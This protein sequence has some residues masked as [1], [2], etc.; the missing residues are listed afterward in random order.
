MKYAKKPSAI[1]ILLYALSVLCVS[2][3]AQSNPIIQENSLPGTTQWQLSNPAN[4]TDL[5]IKGYASATSVNQG[6]S[7]DFHVAVNPVQNFRIDIYRLGWYD[8]DG[9]RLVKSISSVT[10]ETQPDL[11]IDADTGLISAPWNI[12]HTLT[13]PTS[14][15]SGIY[16]AKITN[17]AGFDNHI[18]FV[19][20]DDNRQADL[21]YQ[22]PVTTYQ[23]YNSFPNDQ[24]TGKSLYEFS[25]FGLPTLTGNKRAVRVSFNRPYS[26]GGSGL[27]FGWE[28]EFIRWVERE[29]YDIAYSTNIDTHRAGSKLI[30]YRAFLSVGH[31]EYWSKEMYDAAEKARNEGVH[32]GF[33]GSNNVYWQ[34]RLDPENGVPN[35]IVTSYKDP[36]LDPINN[37]DLKTDLWRNV[38]RPEQTLI[39]IQFSTLN[40]FTTDGSANGDFVVQNTYHW[41]Y[42]GTGFADGDVVPKIIG[43]EIDTFFPNTPKPVGQGYTLLAE[44]PF[45]DF[46]NNVENAHASIYQAPKSAWVFATGSLSWNWALDRPGFVDTRIQKMAANVLDR[47]VNAN[48]VSKMLSP[49]PES[50]LP[51]GSIEFNWSAIAEA[52]YW[53]EVGASPGSSEYYGAGQ[54]DETSATL[55]NLPTDGS[56]V[57]IRLWTILNG[58]WT[59]NDYSYITSDSGN[60]NLAT[61]V[62]PVPG[63]TLLS[64]AATFAWTNVNADQHWLEVGA[65]P[66]GGEYYGQ[67]QGTGTFVTVDNLPTD[68]STIYVRLWT[69]KNNSWRF[70][71]YQFTATTASP[72]VITEPTDNQ[73]E[74][75][76][77]TF[78]W[79]DVGADQYWLEVGATPGGGEYYGQDQGTSTSAT[80]SDLPNDGSTIYVRLWTIRGFVWTPTTAEFTAPTAPTP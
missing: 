20:R 24:T 61:L 34:I 30:D 59:Y 21:L 78:S 45:V 29:G 76:T 7:I 33:F 64:A 36:Q 4:D 25:S 77:V 6:E 2:A 74:T 73:L 43:Y 60:D 19:V 28:L 23:A 3:L 27:L 44:S 57:Y 41:V 47:F 15:V 13:I 63:A 8:G 50:T 12:S 32:L 11:D 71:D 65:T 80:I 17:A 53:L 75:T 52:D 46:A 37:P 54:G 14:W 10:G 35:R 1:F 79:E 40:D 69:I 55:D 68:G 66:G 18:V 38:G 58:A 5:Q 67:D 26:D 31:D 39:G 16:L 9:G 51:A 72:A 62:Q 22:Q 48:N 70:D 56:T 42:N 49:Q